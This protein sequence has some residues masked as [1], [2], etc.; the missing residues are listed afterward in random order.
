MTRRKALLIAATV[1][2]LVGGILGGIQ[3]VGALQNGDIDTEMTKSVARITYLGQTMCSGSVVGDDWVLTAL[4]CNYDENGNT[5]NWHMFQVQ[6]W[7]AGANISPGYESFLSEPPIPMPGGVDYPDDSYKVNYRDVMLLHVA[8]HMPGWAKTIPTAVEWPKQGTALTE[9]GY[10]RTSESGKVPNDLKKSKPGAIVRIDCPNVVAWTRGHLCV[11]SNVSI[12][13]GGDSGG[14]LVWWINNYWQQ[15]GSLIGRPPYVDDSVRYFWSEA[16]G[17]T[18]NWLLSWVFTRD[19]GKTPGNPPL[20]RP[21]DGTEVILR[22]RDT[23]ASWLYEKNDSNKYQGGYRYWI[24]DGETYN[25][26]IDKG[27][28][29]IDIDSGADDASKLGL[30]LRAIEALPD[31]KGSHASCAPAPRPSPT[32]APHPTVTP[33]TY[34]Q[35]TVTPPHPQP[36]PPPPPTVTPISHHPV[37]AYDNYGQSNLAGHAM[38]RGNPGNYLSMPGGTA[39][40][41]FTVPSG[42]ASLSSAMVQIDPDATVTAHFSISVN[43][44]VAATTTATAV[45]DTHFNFGS[46]SVHAG[47][48]ITL[49]ITFSATYGKIITVYTVGN[50]GGRFTASNSCPDGAPNYTT[51][52]SGLRAV[53]SGMS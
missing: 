37:N 34:A 42:V 18:R 10:G 24:P 3:L 26:L 40:Q 31:M 29:V 28:H 43:G 39:T 46:V 15:V 13:W 14:P 51:T 9:Y 52:S 4:H 49:S 11:S 32:P 48:T 7:R 5:R 19:N 44:H 2:L 53:V 1:L 36:T 20:T 41:T 25:C 47:D 35:P 17:D 8:T 23:G 33:I 21:A 22:D 27:V 30:P 50:P 38:C 12:S 45:G 16:D 6:L